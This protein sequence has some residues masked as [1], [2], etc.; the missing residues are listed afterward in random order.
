M[1]RVLS[2]LLVIGGPAGAGKTSIADAVAQRLDARVF[3]LADSAGDDQHI[4]DLGGLQDRLDAH[5]DAPLVVIEGV[6]ALA[7]PPIRW[8]ARWTVYVDTPQDISLARRALSQDDPRAVLRAY[9]DG[10]RD[11]QARHVAPGRQLADLVVD[12]AE[13]LPDVAARI[14]L[15][16][17]RNTR[18]AA[19]S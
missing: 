11:A 16:I 19:G 8:A 10:G 1:M 6:F 4:V 7:L 14:V 18:T 12:G 5:E 2:P 9:L 15:M 3:G 17:R 13:P